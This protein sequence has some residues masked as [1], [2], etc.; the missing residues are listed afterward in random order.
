[1]STW[2]TRVNPWMAV[3]LIA[4]VA[5]ASG[6]AWAASKTSSKAITACV[7][8]HGGAIYVAKKCKR[9]DKRLSWNTTGPRGATG[10]T[11]A[12]GTP[13]A[14]GTSGATGDQ[15]I[16]GPPG[17]VDTSQ[18]L[19]GTGSVT[20][21]HL[22]TVANA[23]A[24]VLADIAGAGK[25]EITSC[26]GGNQGIKFTNTTTQ[27][28]HAVF[29][30]D[31]DGVGNQPDTHGTLGPGVN[32]QSSLDTSSVD[33]MRLVVSVGTTGVADFTVATDRTAGGE[34][35]YWGEVYVG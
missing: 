35:V 30:T 2:P 23:H 27:T 25:F 6:G 29:S 34:C 33:V 16:Q 26:A 14:P 12:A 28:E 22:V 24:A 7:R 5:A 9:H 20:P 15:G 31:T 4:S 19:H 8:H 10:A 11:G 3:A 13:G 32:L 17:P 18:L 21:I 1:M